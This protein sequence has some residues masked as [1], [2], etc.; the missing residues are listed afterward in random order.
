MGRLTIRCV[1]LGAALAAG[2]HAQ[3]D[4]LVQPLDFGRT[5]A[6]RGHVAPLI[7]T[8]TD[9]GPVEP[10]F[11]LGYVSLMLKQTAAQQA[12]LAQLLAAQQDPASASYHRWLTPEE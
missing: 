7:R 11:T 3:Q 9:A 6:L 5:V 10:G 8:A 1:L 12:E 2:L 4:R